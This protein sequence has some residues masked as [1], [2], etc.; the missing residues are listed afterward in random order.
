M[1][2]RGTIFNNAE[3]TSWV[4]FEGFLKGLKVKTQYL[5][6]EKRNQVTQIRTIKSFASP[7]DGGGN[8]HPPEVEE[9]T[10]P[11]QEVW[12]YLDDQRDFRK[13]KKKHPKDG[14]IMDKYMNVDE[15]FKTSRSICNPR[16]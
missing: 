12:F 3:A 9:F 6:D 16:L 1:D 4:A 10:A 13:Q 2:E 15:I 8:D 7:R 11:P 5:K 14:V